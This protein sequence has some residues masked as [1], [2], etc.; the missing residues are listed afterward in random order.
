MS[1]VGRVGKTVAVAS[2]VPLLTATAVLT[3]G[4]IKE[5]GT[6]ETQQVS[7]W[8]YRSREIAQPSLYI[9]L[10]PFVFGAVA[11]YATRQRL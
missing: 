11:Y 5:I 1:L 10:V 6:H 4:V 3:V 9:S 7:S 2:A 8:V